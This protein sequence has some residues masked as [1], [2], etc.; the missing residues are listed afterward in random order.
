MTLPTLVPP[1]PDTDRHT[2]LPDSSFDRLTGFSAPH[3]VLDLLVAAGRPCVMDDL[4]DVHRQ[5]PDGKV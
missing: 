5:S 3:P 1:S 4:G 2:H